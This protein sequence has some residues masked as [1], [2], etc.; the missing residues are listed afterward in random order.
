LREEETDLARKI[1][2]ILVRQAKEKRRMTS[3]QILQYKAPDF[4]MYLNFFQ[5]NAGAWRST[6]N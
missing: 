3:R 6:A 2:L 1:R 4:G 5:L